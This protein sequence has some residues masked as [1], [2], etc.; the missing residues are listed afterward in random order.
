MAEIGGVKLL[1]MDDGVLWRLSVPPTT[2][3]GVVR[4]IARALPRV[5]AIQTMFDWAGGL[6][7]LTVEGVEDAAHG[8][9]LGAIAS[10]G[11]HATLIRA[12]GEI[13]RRVP[14][15]HPRDPGLAALNARVK[16]GFDPRGI[17][18][19]GRLSADY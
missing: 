18:N 19:P 8:V 4:E 7:W 3:A 1:P 16:R 5:G 11:G 12:P 10:G 13:R 15:F 14:V 9:V 2:A 17:L 6:I